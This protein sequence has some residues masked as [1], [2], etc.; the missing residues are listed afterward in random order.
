MVRRY[1]A[2]GLEIKAEKILREWNPDVLDRPG[3][4]D[5]E[6]FAEQH[7]RADINWFR[8]SKDNTVL[9]LTCFENRPIMVY[10]EDGETEQ[11]IDGHEHMII[12]CPSAWDEGGE[13]RGR[14]TIAHECSHVLL[15]TAKDLEQSQEG[16]A[17]HTV[18]VN[19]CVELTDG[20]KVQDWVEWQ[21]NRLGACLLMP[22]TMMKAAV[23]DVAEPDEDG[24][25]EIALDGVQALA[26]LFDVSV[27]AMKIRVAQLQKEKFLR[28]YLGEDAQ[29][30]GVR[31]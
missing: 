14:F 17:P 10:S 20:R 18:A 8:L 31:Q 28:A 24:D 11:I 15:H 22:K 27:L 2:R 29:I 30:V 21:A 12:L 5:I 6:A 13:S 9:G 16:A 4:I 1:S 26:Q 3:R 25:Y 23:P 19:P 7:A